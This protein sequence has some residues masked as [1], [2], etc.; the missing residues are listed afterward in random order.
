MA[1]TEGRAS[2]PEV[3]YRASHLAVVQ[4]APHPSYC[5]THTCHYTAHL[6]YN[7]HLSYVIPTC[8]MTPVVCPSC[9]FRCHTTHTCPDHFRRYRRS[10]RKTASSS[11]ASARTLWRLPWRRKGAHTVGL[12]LRAAPADPRV[13]VINRVRHVA[14]RSV[15]Q[16]STTG[17]CCQPTALQHAVLH[18]ASVATCFSFVA[19]WCNAVHSG[20]SLA[21]RSASAAL[22]TE[23]T[24]PLRC[25]P[26]IHRCRPSFNTP[27]PEA[28]AKASLAKVLTTH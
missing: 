3:L 21:D 18:Y 19:T 22:R 27:T 2:T 1:P 14:A 12:H 10:T 8:N 24:C 25:N 6:S 13:P 5:G 20:L 28:F 9:R 7:T 4:R 11:R 17:S 26:F 15:L 23:R 16:H